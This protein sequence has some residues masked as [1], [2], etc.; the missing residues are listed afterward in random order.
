MHSRRPATRHT[1]CAAVKKGPQKG[2]KKGDDAPEEQEQL[3][4]AAM[5]A[6]EIHEVLAG[7]KD[8]KGRIVAGTFLQPLSLSS[9][10]VSSST[11]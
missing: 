1:A 2:S 3:D 9:R 6:A 10:A 5:R 7:L 11:A 4:V 8:F